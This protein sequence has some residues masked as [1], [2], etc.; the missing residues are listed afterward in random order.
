MKNKIIILSVLG[1]I[2]V[3]GIIFTSI[4]L[5][6]NLDVV[7]KQSLSSFK[8]VTVQLADN[9]KLNEASTSWIL[10]SPD[11]SAYFYW[12]TDFSKTNNYDIM[13]ELAIEPF[14]QAGLDKNKLPE[15]MLSNDVIIVGT[16]LSDEKTTYDGDFSSYESYKKIVKSKRN[17]IKYHAELDH[18]GIDLGNGNLFEWAKDMNTNDKDIVFVLNPEPFI[19][20]GVNPEKVDGWVYAKV[21]T[22]K[23]GKKIEVYKLLKPFNLK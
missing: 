19:D 14:I 7:G 3:I 16:K 18:Y 8:E 15:E 12:S 13:L 1:L 9:I 5:L 17:S 10:S 11:N 23:D 22:M 4:K 21:S 2:T 6:K 20:A